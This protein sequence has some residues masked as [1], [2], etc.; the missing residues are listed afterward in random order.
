MIP[1]QKWIKHQFNFDID[2]GWAYNILNRIGDTPMRLK[3]HFGG[4]MDEPL[5]YEP[6]GKW[7]IKK[8]IGHL[9]DLEH[10]HMK[11]LKEFA[12]LKKILSPADMSNAA[13]ESATHNKKNIT[14]LI[15]ELE[16]GR[17]EFINK[18]LALPPE[19]H[20]H[21]ALH[22][23]LNAVMKPVDLLFFVAEHDDHHLTSTLEIKNKMER[24]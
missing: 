19:S 9:I 15:N 5:S 14:D 17:A 16:K 10:L 24:T 20:L 18:F 1:R 8:H 7:S 23:R 4:M 2:P 12:V 21:Q 11:R 22:E 13:T 6:N 3:Y